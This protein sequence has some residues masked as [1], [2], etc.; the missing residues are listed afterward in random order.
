MKRVMSA[1]AVMVI[2]ILGGCKRAEKPP[3]PEANATI[4]KGGVMR[5]VAAIS[6]QVLGY[7]PEMGPQDITFAFP[8]LEPLM[9]YTEKRALEP[10]LC[11]KVDIDPASP[12][13][14]FHFRKGIRFHDG[15]DLT[16]EVARWNF[17]ELID[18]R[19]LQHFEKVKKIEVLDADT[20][21]L[22][23][24]EY[25]NQLIHSFGYVFV[26]SKAGI[27]KHGKEWARVNCIGTGPFRQVEYK[28][29][30]YL[31]WT[32][33]ADYWRKD[34]GLPYLQGMEV[35][36]IPDPVTA[37]SMITTK[38]ADLWMDPGA[39]YQKMMVDRGYVRQA[40]YSGLSTWLMPNYLRPDGKWKNRKLREALECAIDREALTKAFGYGFN[41]PMT[42]IAPPGEWG[43]DASLHRGYDPAKSRR[44]IREA[45]YREPVKVKIL[46]DGNGR[47]TAAGIK[48]FL[49]AAGFE[50]EIDIA[51]SGRYF[52]SI[53]TS[54]WD[55]LCFAASGADA[56]FLVTIARWFSPEARVLP[57]FV[58]PQ[59]FKDLWHEA[60]SKTS[61]QDQEA[62]TR[63]MVRYIH[64]EA[65]IC[66]LFMF[67]SAGIMQRNVHTNYLREG[68]SKWNIAEDWMG[69]R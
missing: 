35:R 14:T 2:I 66:P 49:D 52:G 20:L 21:R 6:P 26:A 23:L 55:D 18:A 53:Y 24:T 1:L 45:G 5:V 65:L 68:M 8:G 19:K 22:N 41:I 10:F 47:D 40:G 62:M 16:A 38:Q 54:G 31:K 48:G 59:P 44:L 9:T 30:A 69:R 37:S 34:K 25:D 7:P 58:K 33:F 56:N 4:V 46:S 11:S 36:F 32:K 64:D 67:P 57:G 50:C 43:Y 15:S 42:L 29:D 51:D 13:I 3:A 12:S 63:K 27:E 39:Q 17:Q 60:L 28:R 61:D